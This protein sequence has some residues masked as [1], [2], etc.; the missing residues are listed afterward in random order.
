MRILPILMILSR[1]LWFSLSKY[2]GS[3]ISGLWKSSWSSSLIEEERFKKFRSVELARWRAWNNL[4]AA[5]FISPPGG[6]RSQEIK[7]LQAE[8]RKKM[9]QAAWR[10]FI[11]LEK[12]WGKPFFTKDPRYKQGGRMKW[13]NF[14]SFCFEDTNFVKLVLLCMKKWLHRYVVPLIY[15]SIIFIPLICL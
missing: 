1:G 15:S 5:K 8:F 4:G 9:K 2:C 3:P 12:P 6:R 14:F 10:K 13:E 7:S 11:A